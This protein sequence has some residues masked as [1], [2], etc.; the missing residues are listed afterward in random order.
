[1]KI[2]VM[3][4]KSLSV[5]CSETVS[6]ATAAYSVH[7]CRLPFYL[8]QRRLIIFHHGCSETFDL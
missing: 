3:Q 8:S 6:A 4:F 7:L 5:A 2:P 1:M